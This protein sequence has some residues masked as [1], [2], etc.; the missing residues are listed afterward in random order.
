MNDVYTALN[1]VDRNTILLEDSET[2]TD[3]ANTTFI[4]CTYHRPFKLP[5]TPER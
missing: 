5:P 4:A 3:E 1:A 2:Q